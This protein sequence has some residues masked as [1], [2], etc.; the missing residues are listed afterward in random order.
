MSAAAATQADLPGVAGKPAVL[1]DAGAL[2]GHAP[3]LSEAT[4]VEDDARGVDAGVSVLAENVDP[5]AGGGDGVGAAT[6]DEALAGSLPLADDC[7]AG[8]VELGRL[9]A[10]LEPVAEHD[11]DCS[12][13]RRTFLQLAATTFAVGCDASR[14][15]AWEHGAL[16]LAVTSSHV[17]W[18][19]G[20]DHSALVVV[21][22]EGGEPRVLYEGMPT[23]VGLAPGPD[24][25]F[26]AS[27]RGVER[28]PYHGLRGALLVAEAQGAH[29]VVIDGSDLFW[30]VRGAGMVRRADLRGEEVTTLAEGPAWANDVAVADD[31]IHWTSGEPGRL[32]RV[33]RTGGAVETVVDGVHGLG[34]VVVVGAHVYF[35]HATGVSRIALAG[36]GPEP[37]AEGRS[38]PSALRRHGDG[39]CWSEEGRDGG[40]RIVICCRSR[41]CHLQQ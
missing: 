1:G 15:T 20:V 38:S 37:I 6:A 26:V 9:L 25:M 7:P 12:V 2:S 30:L 31:V 39:L 19:S 24:A 32:S 13:R 21:R 14:V 23:A 4:D 8:L 34:P 16:A 40:G 22:R 36:G 28:A 27:G 35:G 33:A 18:T 3:R 5:V 11:Q 10:G 29:R 17:Y 41:I